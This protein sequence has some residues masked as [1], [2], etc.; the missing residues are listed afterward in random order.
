MGEIDPNDRP[1]DD[2]PCFGGKLGV[3]NGARD[4]RGGTDGLV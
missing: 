1:A 3:K 4:G 2:R